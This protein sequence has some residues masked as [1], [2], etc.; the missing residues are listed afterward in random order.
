MRDRGEQLLVTDGPDRK[1]KHAVEWNDFVIFFA[2]ARRLPVLLGQL[3]F[4]AIKLGGEV[5]VKPVGR[6]VVVGSSSSVNS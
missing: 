5:G 1:A 6:L 2:G 3:C 4:N